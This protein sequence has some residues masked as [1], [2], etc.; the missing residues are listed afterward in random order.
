MSELLSNT[1]RSVQHQVKAQPLCNCL[2]SS[3]K[4]ARCRLNLY[5]MNIGIFDYFLVVKLKSNAKQYIVKLQNNLVETICSADP[6]VVENIKELILDKN[7]LSNLI[8]RNLYDEKY[9]ILSKKEL[10][11]RYLSSRIKEYHYSI[12]LKL[13]LMSKYDSDE[14]R[15]YL[16][17]YP[18]TKVFKK[19]F[20]GVTSKTKS[21]FSTAFSHNI[22]MRSI[23]F[24]SE[25]VD[26]LFA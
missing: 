21:E 12:E 16:I 20:L 2:N 13:K 4:W 8:D 19:D 18:V 9:R 23:N 25:E 14:D 15:T 5:A 10:L 7:L 3:E 26:E 11:S 24:F 1:F 17:D 22:S 6:Q